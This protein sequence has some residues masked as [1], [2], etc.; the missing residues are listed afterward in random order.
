MKS[1]V[2]LGII[3]LV[4]LV[5]VSPAMASPTAPPTCGLNLVLKTDGTWVT[6]PGANGT[7]VYSSVG[8][9]FTFTATGLPANTAYT[10]ISYAEPYPGTGSVVL[11]TG[12]TNGAGGITITGASLPALVYNIYSSG[13]YAGQTGA[14]IWLVPTAGL[15]SGALAGWAPTTYLFETRLIQSNEVCS[16]SATAQIKGSFTACTQVLGIATEFTQSPDFGAMIVGDNFLNEVG[17]IKVTSQCTGWHVIT[18][19]SEPNNEGYMTYGAKILTNKLN[20]KDINAGNTFVPVISTWSGFGATTNPSLSVYS[21]PLSFK[22]T[23]ASGDVSGN[24]GINL[25]YSVSAV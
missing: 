9:P 1:Y 17:N 19:T 25:T 20:Q 12:A 14:K 24:Y 5:F 22:Q 11:G 4:M 7:I 2:I 16:G 13:E 6:I 15:N 8:S 10:L 3:A 18:P 23:V 21:Y